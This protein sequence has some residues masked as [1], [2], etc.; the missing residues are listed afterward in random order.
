[1]SARRKTR[2]ISFPVALLATAAALASPAV[3][4]RLAWLGPPSATQPTLQARRS[5]LAA[6]AAGV[7]AG[8]PPLTPPA[9]ARQSQ[10]KKK[11]AEDSV[12]V[13]LLALEDVSQM[14]SS[15]AGGKA[16]G[17]DVYSMAKRLLIE[18]RIAG[19]LRSSAS[20]LVAQCVSDPEAIK[21]EDMAVDTLVALKGKTRGGK[22]EGERQE[23]ILKRLRLAE[24]SLLEQVSCLRGADSRDDVEPLIPKVI[25]DVE[26]Q[27][28]A[29]GIFPWRRES[30][31][32][33]PLTKPEDL[34]D[35]I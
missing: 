18:Q 32:K 35:P 3:L 5:L 14:I 23:L 28:G 26:S 2:C 8:A 1:M 13:V 11:L 21:P 4:G 20:A 7:L 12:R 31:E 22:L 6:S 19:S 24:S 15:V 16:K 10:A 27:I 30:Y 33:P 9:A 34:D 17:E 25:A 29:R